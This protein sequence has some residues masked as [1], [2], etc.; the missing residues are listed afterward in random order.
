MVVLRF[1]PFRQLALVIAAVLVLTMAVPPRWAWAA[2]LGSSADGLRLNV[3]A[4]SIPINLSSPLPKAVWNG[5][6]AAVSQTALGLTLPPLGTPALTVGAIATS[7]GPASGGGSHAESSV[8]GVDLLTAVNVG[9]IKTSCDMT[10]GGITTVTDL[11]NLKLNNQSVVN[12]DVNLAINIPGLITGAIDHRTAT[13]NAGS[14]VLTYKVAAIDLQLLS[15]LSGISTGGGLVV[16]ES[17][18]SGTAKLGTV[19]TGSVQLAPGE[20]P[21][22]PT[23]TV[24]GTGE[25]GTPNTT[26]KIPVPP[27][28]Y[29]LGTPVVTSGGGTCNTT[30][31]AGFITCSGVTVPGA[32]GGT[33]KISLPVSINANAGNVADWEPASGTIGVSTTPVPGAG[34]P[35][36]PAISGA[37][38]LVVASAPC[39]SVSFCT[40]GMT[41]LFPISAFRRPTRLSGM[42][43]G[44]MMPHHETDS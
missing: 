5:T 20:S 4:L 39:A 32:G 29:T 40:S 42:P 7:A 2:T 33:A 25:V 13:Y 11:A 34:N 35:T 41:M 1:H 30:D 23:V 31:N 26:I 8:A 9:A 18:C 17:V 14:N 3:T 10:A 38:V 16:A 24:S 22:A 37:G 6:G 27:T 15:G 28:G 44:P 43:A 19:T 36:L 12:P 21:G